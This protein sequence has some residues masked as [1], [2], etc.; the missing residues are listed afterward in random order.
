LQALYNLNDNNSI[1]FTYS[2]RIDRP[3]GW[4]LNPFPD[5]ADSLNVRLGN[6]NLQP[7]FIHSLELG[8]MLSFERAD[9]TSNFFYRH[10]DGQVDFIVRVEDGISYRQPE[11]LNTSETYG[12]ELISTAQLTEWWTLNA[13]YSIF[14]TRVDGTNLDTDF[15]N[16]GLSWNA[17]L[18][19]DVNL[20]YQINFQLTGNY[21]AP[22]I[23]AQG[24]DLARYYV[25]M[26]LQRSFFENKADLSVSF[27]DVFDVRRFAGEN[28][29]PEF[30]QTFNFKRES[31]IVLVT[32]GYNF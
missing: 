22:E 20:P 12:F 2:R 5:I 30:S 27:R 15:T 25:D 23:E 28:V 9:I 11:N 7:E 14:Q 4:R 24:R 26:S 13:S 1:K 6:P 21:T 10:V 8:H 19:T 3:N 18:T 17:K 32:L 16:E 31:Q 29:S